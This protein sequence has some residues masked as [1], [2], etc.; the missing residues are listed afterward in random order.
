MVFLEGQECPN[1]RRKAKRYQQTSSGS[2]LKLHE[3]WQVERKRSFNQESLFYN[4]VCLNFSKFLCL[5]FENS[6]FAVFSNF[7]FF[8]KFLFKSHSKVPFVLERLLRSI[9]Y[10][11]TFNS[12]FSFLVK[13]NIL[14]HDVVISANQGFESFPSRS[15]VLSFQYLYVLQHLEARQI[16]YLYISKS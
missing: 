1:P 5:G 13:F 6:D 3:I 15:R 2:E 12:I 7:H 11:F 10:N 16:I 9:V 8:N 14:P 4:E